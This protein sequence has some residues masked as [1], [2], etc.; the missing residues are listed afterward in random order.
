M[1]FTRR[2]INF[3]SDLLV[4]F[5]RGFLENQFFDLFACQ[6]NLS[7]QKSLTFLSCTFHYYFPKTSSLP[8][9]LYFSS[10][11]NLSS[12]ANFP[13]ILSIGLLFDAIL[14]CLANL[15]FS[16][17]LTKLSDFQTFSPWKDFEKMAAGE[18]VIRGPISMGSLESTSIW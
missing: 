4:I 7:S 15:L 12:L 10:P 6:E 1:C 16:F 13:S 5:R 9:N 17:G 18:R 8:S 11:F 14:T 3:F 2:K